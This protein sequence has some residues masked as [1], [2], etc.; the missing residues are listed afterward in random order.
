MQ[1][2][3][4]DNNPTGRVPGPGVL[5][6]EVV[7]V[8][9]LCLGQSAVYSVISFLDKVTRAPLREQTTSMNNPLSVRPWF[10]LAY[11]LLDIFFAL[12]PVVL[13]LYLLSR[14]LGLG[15]RH[16]GFDFARPGRDAAWGAGLFVAMGL[17]T[18]GVYAAGRMLGVTTALSVAN[19][20]DY[21]WTVPVLLLSAARHAVLEEVIMLAFLFAY[22]KALRLSPWLMII[23]SALLRGSYHLYQ[24]FGP[25]IGNALMGV[26]FGWF[27]LKYGRVM[28]LVIAHFLLDAVGFVGFA[29]IGPAIGIGS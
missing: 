7:L 21:W 26:V 3:L 5:K 28:P 15:A 11:Q 14:S 1:S 9:A 13:A 10:D 25:F 19:L 12:V 2:N 18:L 20:A 24:G 23:A 29:L 8:L 16:L 4:V 22:G 17:G 6:F 27:Y